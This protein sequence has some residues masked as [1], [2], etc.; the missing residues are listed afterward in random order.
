MELLR[1]SRS[2]G[3]WCPRSVPPEAGR[4]SRRRHPLCPTAAR[5]RQRRAGAQ[6]ERKDTR[7]EVSCIQL[8]LRRAIGS[9]SD[10]GSAGRAAGGVGSR[11]ARPPWG[12]DSGS[13]AGARAASCPPP[14]PDIPIRAGRG[15]VPAVRSRGHACA[16]GVAAACAPGGACPGGGGARGCPR[17][18]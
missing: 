16:R 14:G 2:T 12:C 11:S 10:S 7:Y 6:D 13:S 17:S 5:P 4:P 8:A 18:A 15:S 9:P 3:V 1:R